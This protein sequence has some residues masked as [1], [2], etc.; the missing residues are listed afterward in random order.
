MSPFHIVY[1]REPPSLIT[2]NSNDKDPP[3]IASLLQ[4][5]D[6]VLQ[7]LKKNLIRAQVQMKHLA[8][9][10]EGNFICRGTMGFC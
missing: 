9:V 5:H 3:N 4:Q 6:K 10:T 1:G 7:Q 2:Y 8:E